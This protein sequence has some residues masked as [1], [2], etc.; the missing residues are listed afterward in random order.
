MQWHQSILRSLAVVGLSGLLVLSA[1]PARGQSASHAAPAPRA[2]F[3]DESILADPFVQAEGRR[4]LDLLYNMEFEAANE[5]FAE[6]NRRYPNH[7]VGP[8]LEGLNIWWNHIMLDLPD[9][10]HDEDFFAAMEAVVARCDEILD[11]DPDNLDALFLKGAA[12]GFRAR[13]YSNR[14]RWMKAVTDGRGA[15]SAVRRVGD[16][17]PGNPDYVFGKG[18]Y[19]YYA[20]IIPEHY[21]FAKAVMFFLPDGDR[22]EG[23]DQ[24]ERA[25]EHG[26]YIQTEAVYFLLQI[27]YLYETDYRKSREYVSWLRRQHPDNPYFHS[28][29]GRVYARW[30]QWRQARNEFA[31]VLERY[32]QRQTGY[33]DYFAQQALYFLARE[34]MQAGAYDAALD[35]LVK[36][37]ALTTDE[38]GENPYKVL[39]RLRQGMSYDALG[40]RA[41]ATQRYREVL[42]LD[43][44]DGAHDRARKYLETPYGG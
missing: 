11:E 13:L 7:P 12:L 26:Q 42:E 1:S 30:G 29:E 17:A 32:Q 33:N 22:E 6:I 21:S 15:I 3:P 40:K 28:F 34:R 24:L 5:I 20:A 38:T 36:L 39:G 23:L 16:L 37:E 31:S 41:A 8:F 9:T 18:M 2:A 10:S 19:D 35:Y 4:G 25:A 44:H 27:H 43:D 14:A